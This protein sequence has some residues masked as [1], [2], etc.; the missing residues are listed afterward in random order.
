[1]KKHI[2][3]IIIG[4][5]IIIVVALFSFRHIIIGHALKITISKKTNET[6]SLDIGNV[7][8]DI[9]NS[10]VSFSNS[11]LLFKNT[12][13]NKEKTIELSELRFNEIK[14]NN[15]SIIRLLFKQEVVAN[16]IIIDKP[17]LWFMENHNPKPFKEKPKEII[18]SL[19]Q[20]HDILKNLVVIVN[21]IEITHGKIDLKSLINNK[22]HSGSVEFKLLL[23]K[24]NTS[25]DN[26]FEKDEILFAEEHFVKL[27]K[28]NYTLPNGD[29]I[30]T[31]YQ[32]VTKLILTQ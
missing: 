15:L 30:I 8:Y 18:N 5:I 27:S 28:F 2:F 21:E 14:I 24:I 16:K 31:H 10:S 22:N 23:K 9:L 29:K 3:K 7:Y 19:K 12:F 32:M 4:I 13:I 25:K 17:S 6:I 11:E 20:H 26:N 1:M